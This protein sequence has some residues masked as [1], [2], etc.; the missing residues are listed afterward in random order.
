MCVLSYASRLME[1][2]GH[3]V[4]S[5]RHCQK[6]CDVISVKGIFAKSV[7]NMFIRQVLTIQILKK[8]KPLAKFTYL[9]LFS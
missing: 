2:D 3:G 8:R 9:Q 4:N 6:I 5:V 1:D 7:T